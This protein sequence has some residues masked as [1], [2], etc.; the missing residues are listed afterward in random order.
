MK[1]T[2]ARKAAS[3]KATARRAPAR[4]ARVEPIP[5]GYHVVT[6][7]LAIKG[8]SEAIG[9]YQ[10]V[11]GARERMRMEAPGGMVGHAELEIG[12]SIVMLADEFPQMEFVGP[13]SRG[14]TTVTMHLYVRDCDAVVAKAQAAGAK[15]ARAVQDQFYGDRSGTI[16][17]PF[18]HVWHVSTH[19]ED[20]SKAELR[21]RAAKAMSE[22]G[23]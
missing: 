2:V 14:G 12:D 3:K 4:A 1:K 21:K 11:F 7:Y 18:G 22:K 23:G 20:L 19:K 10:K 13:R 16:E 8:A 6:P 5:E 15:V 9:W 17:D